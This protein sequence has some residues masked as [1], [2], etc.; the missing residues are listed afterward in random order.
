[1]R[2]AKD[3]RRLGRSGLENKQNKKARVVFS[4]SEEVMLHSG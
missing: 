1:M 3:I 4:P 2:K